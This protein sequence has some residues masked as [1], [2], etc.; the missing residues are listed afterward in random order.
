MGKAAVTDTTLLF[1]M[2]GALL[3]FASIKVKKL[4]N[5]LRPALVSP[6]PTLK[7][8]KKTLLLD[9]GANNENKVE[10]LVKA[11]DEIS[12]KNT[13]ITYLN[14]NQVNESDITNN[15]LTSPQNL[16]AKKNI[17]DFENSDYLIVEEDTYTKAKKLVSANKIIRAYRKYKKRIQPAV[18]YNNI[19]I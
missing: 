14:K 1:F 11:K 7:E 12:N 9:L 10:E 2:T 18:K 8:G 4:D 5:V 17:N 15:S 19:I 6:I 16:R 3:T 13:K